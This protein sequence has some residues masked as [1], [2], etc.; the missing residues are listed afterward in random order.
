MTG[1]QT[2][3]LPISLRS[4]TPLAYLIGSIPFLNCII[5]L[6][7][8][9][10]IPR[11]ETE[12]LVEQLLGRFHNRSDNL[13]GIDIGTGCGCIAISLAHYLPWSRMFATD[14]SVSALHIAKKNAKNLAVSE[15]IQFVQSELFREFALHKITHNSCDFIVS[16]PPY[17]PRTVL[18]TLM[19]EVLAEPRIA[20][21]GGE[22]G[23][24]SIV[25]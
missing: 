21:D 13:N 9:P 25:A 19:P 8:H 10:L 22:G 6:D 20:L 12:I 17:V 18:S 16:N 23:G 14:I 11:P 5:Y 3:A 24:I 1:V 15:R 4:G 7:S 2:C